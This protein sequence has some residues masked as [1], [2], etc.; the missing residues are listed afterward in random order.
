MYSANYL[1]AQMDVPYD[2]VLTGEP[3]LA[4]RLADAQAILAAANAGRYRTRGF[5]AG[6]PLGPDAFDPANAAGAAAAMNAYNATLRTGNP[7]QVHAAVD[8]INRYHAAMGEAEVIPPADI[9][10]LRT[11][12]SSAGWLLRKLAQRE[13][14]PRLL[15]DP[16]F[17]ADLLARSNAAPPPPL[18]RTAPVIASTDE[19]PAGTETVDAA[20]HRWRKYTSPFGNIWVQVGLA[21]LLA[22]M[23]GREGAAQVTVGCSPEPLAVVG[24][25]HVQSMGPWECYL[26]NKGAGVRTVSAEEV[27]LAVLSIRPIGPASAAIVLGDRQAR[28]TAAKVV[29]LLTVAGQLSGV[30]LSLASKSNAQLG[31]GL[32]VG[33]QFLPMAID[34]ARGEAPS[35]A[36]YLGAMLREPVTLA[37]GG[38]AT[39]LIFASKQKSPQP[40]MVTI[41]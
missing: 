32:A 17:C 33:S 27:L 13:T 14:P 41:P 8:V 26:I 2:D 3:G 39:R 35:A 40:I 12:S 6:D 16:V 22:V 29:K 15:T 31:T 24:A 23:G 4:A 37:G 25:L 11:S 21:V 28:S 9:D 30:A 20:G 1:L 36:V 7:D 5:V 10:I 19:V 38:S 34:I 18:P